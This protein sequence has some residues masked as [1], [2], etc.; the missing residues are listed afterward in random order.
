MNLFP[1]NYQATVYYHG[2]EKKNETENTCQR[3]LTQRYQ[4]NPQM[5][6][7]ILTDNLTHDNDIT[8]SFMSQESF[9]LS[10]AL[11][12]SANTIRETGRQTNLVMGCAFPSRF[13]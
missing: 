8:G 2:R 5:D 11:S 3:L 10:S 1:V 13:H 6:D 4:G 7:L 12:G 9:V